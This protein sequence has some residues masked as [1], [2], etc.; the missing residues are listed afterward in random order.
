M[1]ERLRQARKGAGFRTATAAVQ[2]FG[3]RATKY[4][5]HENGQNGFGAED[6]KICAEAFGVRTAW[7]L[8]GDNA[9]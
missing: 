7:L 5:A 4:R 2:Q 3:F 6:A 9:K 1:D 8:R